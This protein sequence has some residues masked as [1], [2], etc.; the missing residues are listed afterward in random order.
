MTNGKRH[1]SALPKV[2]VAVVIALLLGGT[3]AWWWWTGG[4]HGRPAPPPQ[5]YPSRPETSQPATSEPPA[6][7]Q[8]S[9]LEQQF[10]AVEQL[11]KSLPSGNI[12]F[13]S[14]TTMRL[15]DSYKVELLLSASKTVEELQR[16]LRRRLSTEGELEGKSIRI[17]PQ[18]EAVL[19]GQNFQ[20]LAVRPPVQSVS[21]ERV[22]TWQWD[23]IPQKGGTQT[24][25]L[26]IN[27]ILQV[28]HTSV[29]RSI[30]TYAK[31]IQVNVSWNLRMSGFLRENWQWLWA[32]VVVPVVAAGWARWRKRRK[33][34]QVKAAKTSDRPRAS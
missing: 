15:G 24:L 9:V 23:V 8:G 7:N 3:A 4:S 13:N 30:R 5:T 28:D 33:E 32:A 22:T 10:E 11:L 34:R 25:Y 19:S 6:A 26:Q 21:P 2:I 12:A 18:M 27:A 1:S 14:P 31:S 29:P 20:I 17:A 16:E